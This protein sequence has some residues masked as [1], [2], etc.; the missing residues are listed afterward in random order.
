MIIKHANIIYMPTISPLGGIETYV[1]EMVK[2]YKNLD[3]AVVSKMCDSKQ[4]ERIEKYCKVYIHTNEKIECKVAII[5]YD[6]SIINYI[7]EDAEIY[8]TIHA[9]YSNNIYTDKP[10]TNP[11]IKSYI[12]ITKFLQ[13]RMRD[14]LNTDNIILSYNPL[15]ITKKEKEKPLIL[16]SATRLH[17]HKGKERMQL[18]ASAL[19]KAGIN[20]IWYV[21]TGDIGG[22]QSDNVIFIRN[23]LDVDKWI[24]QADYV[25]LLSDSEACSYTINE[26]LYRNIPVI[27]TPLP[28]LKEIGVEDDK[29]A[30][31]M[32][33]D[34]SNIDD[35]V[36][37]I[38]N[39]PSFN[40]MHLKD[41][42]NQLF[43]KDK[44]IYIPDTKIKVR[45]RCIVNFYDDLRLNRRV[46]LNEEFDTNKLRANELVSAKVCEI[47]EEKSNTKAETSPL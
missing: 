14:V 7:N 44:S 10:K 2:K 3:I 5:N 31:I 6:Q 37:K 34:C 16:V 45:V 19:D 8:Q 25:V 12:A 23:R 4:K 29:N 21:I 24:N 41:K 18:L 17:K 9:D 46:V 33:F 47:I 42:Y 30:Y 43:T 28:Y 32:N 11:R 22:I 40:F 35:I 1:Y 27:V 38:C 39:V 36:K 15:T 20:Y 13:E 26:A